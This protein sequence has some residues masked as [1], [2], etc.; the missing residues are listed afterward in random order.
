MSKKRKSYEELCFTD[1]FMFS[2]ILQSNPEICKKII[3]ICTGKKISKIEYPDVQKAVHITAD[4]KGVRFDVYTEDESDTI[5]DVEMQVANTGNL[6]KRSRYYQGMIDLET[7]QHGG[8]YRDLKKTYIIFICMFD[9]FK[10]YITK[11]TFENTCHEVEGLILGDDAKIVFINPF[12]PKPGASDDERAFYSFLQ[13]QVLDLPFAKILDDSVRKAR[14]HEEWKVEYMS[15]LLRD[16]DNY[17]Q[18]YDTGKEEGKEEV[19]K[20]MLI[21]LLTKTDMTTDEIARITNIPKNIIEAE[22]ENLN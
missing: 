8:N 18:G 22:K 1:D 2:K 11:Y 7:L 4:S 21:N 5:Y 15:L 13:G 9:P 17:N 19:R 3:E 20:E 6:S 12:A 10:K 14:L 16:Q